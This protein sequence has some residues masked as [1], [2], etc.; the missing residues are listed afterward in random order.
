MANTLLT[1]DM[2]TKEALRVLHQKLNFV[3]NI[4]RQYDNSFA[5]SGAKIGD[6]LRIRKPVRYT[7]TDGATLGTQD[8][9]E[10]SVSLPITNQKHVP[11]SF[12]SEELTLDI[13]DF[14]KRFIE[15]A[16]AQLA[17]SVE[18]DVLSNRYKDVYNLVGTPGSAVTFKNI[19]E[20]RKKLNDNLA[21]MDGERCVTMNTQANVDLVDGLKGLFQDSSQISKQYKEG[22]M[23]VTAGYNFYENTLIPSH[24]AGAGV[25]DAYLVNGAAESGSA[26]TVDGGAS[27]LV[28][29]DVFTIAGV[30]MVHPET[31][32]STGVLQQFTVTANYAGGAGDISISPPITTSGAYQT[33][34]NVPADNAPLTFVG[35]ASTAFQ[36]SLA[37][38]KSAFTFATADLVLPQGVDFA[39]RQTYDGI[40]LRIIRQ[41]DINTDAF[42][43]RVDVLYGSASLYPQLASRVANN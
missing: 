14:S 22:L 26:I 28:K 33:V 32:Q 34:S 42:P 12:T 19:L 8:S 20:S 15:P 18:F 1:P 13:D 21:P 41:Y 37:F 36:Q 16:M 2:I 35:T 24:T 11:M 9:T 43:C 23:G 7:V 5:K 10:T 4:D 40:S 6:T 17:A 3:G 25:D 29:G 31:R 39:S 30:F 27:A 38:H